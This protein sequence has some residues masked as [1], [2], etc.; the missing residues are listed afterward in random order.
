MDWTNTNDQT[1]KDW[2]NRVQVTSRTYTIN[3]AP[4]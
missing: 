1:D 4:W 3:G 2:S